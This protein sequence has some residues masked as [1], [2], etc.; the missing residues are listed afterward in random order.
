MGREEGYEE[1][2]VALK[3]EKEEEMVKKGKDT[4]VADRREET[5]R[6]TEEDRG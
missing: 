6:M 3:E 1:E 5:R 4:G 2:Q